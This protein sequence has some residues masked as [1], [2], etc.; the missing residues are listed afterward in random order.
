LTCLGSKTTPTTRRITKQ[1]EQQREQQSSVQVIANWIYSACALSAYI[2]SG[3]TRVVP[4]E[5][6]LAKTT[7]ENRSTKLCSEPFF[8]TSSF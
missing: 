4:K 5:P 8:Q 7:Q 2:V 3:H 1:R 6:V